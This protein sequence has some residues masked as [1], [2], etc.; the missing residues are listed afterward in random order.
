MSSS[1]RCLLLLVVVAGALLAGLPASAGAAMALTTADGLTPAQ[2]CA[3]ADTAVTAATADQLDGV[4]LCLI[5]RERAARALRP[6]R[7][8]AEL[9]A[10]AARYARQMVA[11]RFF[12]HVSP[13]GVSLR[14]RVARTGYLRGSFLIGEDIATGIGQDASPAGIVA[15]WMGSPPHR[16]NILQAAFRDA[17]LGIVPG[18]A[19]GSDPDGATYVVDFGRRA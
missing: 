2:A 12:D 9:D 13:T 5:N 6:L 18:L 16:R 10:A 3:G 7:A 4:V 1:H 8:S 11:Q 15:A 17:G 19:T 14:M